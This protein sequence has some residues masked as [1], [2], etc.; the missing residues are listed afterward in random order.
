MSKIHFILDCLIDFAVAVFAEIF[1][2]L[3]NPRN[4][5]ALFLVAVAAMIILIAKYYRP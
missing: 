1:D 3:A 4:L 5:F 2:R